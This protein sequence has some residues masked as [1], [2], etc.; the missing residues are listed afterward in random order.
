MIFIGD[1]QRAVYLDD[2][3]RV[4]FGAKRSS[5]Q[6]VATLDR[7]AKDRG[8]GNR[9]QGDQRQNERIFNERL[10]MSTAVPSAPVHPIYPRQKPA[11]IRLLRDAA[12]TQS[13]QAIA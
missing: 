13:P 3:G 5:G 7:G 6:A 8:Q 10:S 2:T 4:V 12:Q 11:P 9:H 1:T